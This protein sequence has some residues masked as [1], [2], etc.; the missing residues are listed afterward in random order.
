MQ[1]LFLGAP[2][3]GK[4]TQCKRLARH[5]ALPHLSS[6]D[7]LR[8]AVKA[9]TPAGEAAQSF[10]EKGVLVPD[11]I[12]IDMFREKL[13]QSVCDKG[14]IL[15]GFPRNVAQAKSL[16]LLLEEVNK[17]LTV[18][19]NMQVDDR[20]L[21]S[22]IV[23]RSVCSNK[24]CNAPYHDH[25][26]KPKVSNVCDLCG[27]SLTKRSDDKKELVEQ[28]LKTYSEETAPLIEYYDKRL[29]LRTVDGEGDPDEIFADLL[30]TLKV[31]A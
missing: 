10:M 14:F 2:G 20:L 17:S 19:I 29:L 22:R 1:I 6:G 12:L 26:A 3:A 25:F 5:L 24:A 8:E 31:L 7:L 13:H 23:G 28:R 21:L 15:D 18:V 30:R 4:G 9:K 27:S 16:D 11:A